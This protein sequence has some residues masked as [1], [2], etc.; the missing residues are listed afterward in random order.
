MTHLPFLFEFFIYC[1]FTF[2]IF[3][4][5]QEPFL[6]ILKKLQ[7]SQ[8]IRH[9]TVDGKKAKVFRI[10][11]QKKEGTPTGAGV[12]IWFSVF[13]TILFS[14]ALSFFGLIDQ[15][16]LQRKEVYL[17]LF[18]LLF[19]GILG[20][21]DDWLNV[22]GTSKKKGMEAVSKF[23]ILLF[24][25]TLGGLWF[26]FKLDFTELFI[27]F[28]GSLN[29]GIWFLLFFIFVFTA[30]SN[31]VNITDGLDGLASGVLIQ[32]FAVFAAL[33]FVRGQFF[34]SIFCGI[35]I[36]ALVAFLWFNAPPAKFFMGDTGA[37]SLGATLAVIATMTGTITTLPLIGFIFV[38]ETF[39]V[40]LQLFS[41]KF[42]NKKIFHI[43]PLHHHFEK[44]GWS[45]SQIVMRFW[46]INGIFAT[47]GF[48][49]EMAGN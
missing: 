36:S 49:I 37:L 6:K 45:E 14:R 7:F 42:F 12:L 35:V 19:V 34:L 40:I 30:T 23:L 38:I 46:I 29:L 16:L 31:A 2:F 39:S 32:S 26:V 21:F 9:H 27:P 44:I 28:W 8:K 33:S 20:L 13:L 10:L 43:A 5:L 18:T 3:F 25:G 11:H 17:P 15:S 24:F 41:K 47:M 22:C 48:L 1:L 4:F